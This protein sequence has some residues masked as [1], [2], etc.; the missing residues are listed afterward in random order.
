MAVDV[1]KLPPVLPLDVRRVEDDGR[2]TQWTTD[3]DAYQRNWFATTAVDLQ[4]QVNTVSARSAR[5]RAR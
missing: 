5:S 2:A 4:T 1:T 3:W